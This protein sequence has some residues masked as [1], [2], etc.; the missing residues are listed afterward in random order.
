MQQNYR[1]GQIKRPPLPET[2]LFSIK[3]FIE[4]DTIYLLF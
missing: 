2:F 4:K 1:V 3:L